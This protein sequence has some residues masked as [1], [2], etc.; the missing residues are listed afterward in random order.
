MIPPPYIPPKPPPPPEPEPPTMVED[1]VPMWRQWWDRLTGWIGEWFDFKRGALA[2][3]PVE[4]FSSV[5]FLLVGRLI[6]TVAV[7][8]M[9]IALGAWAGYWN[10]A[11]WD[12]PRT[13]P[14]D[15]LSMVER[16]SLFDCV[17]YAYAGL[18]G[19]LLSFMLVFKWW[20]MAPLWIAIFVVQLWWMF[21]TMT[22]EE[23]RP[24]LAPAAVV[25]S[26]TQFYAVMVAGHWGDVCPLGPLMFTG[27]MAAVIGFAFVRHWMQNNDLTPW[28][29]FETTKERFEP[30]LH[31]WGAF[32][33]RRRGA[34]GGGE[35][36]G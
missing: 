30:A 4:L 27:M 9:G 35:N 10:E 23:V 15:V 28:E 6:K 36:E 2:W 24:W 31:R 14:V 7:I 1:E 11:T 13:Y 32:V 34:G 8:G 29:V 25:G 12:E 17:W 5:P 3:D 22:D 26:A 33:R 20:W 18:L 16:L 21:Q 19:W